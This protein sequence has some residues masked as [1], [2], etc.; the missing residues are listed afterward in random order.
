LA[1]ARASAKPT[2]DAAASA[3]LEVTTA[4][5]FRVR[6]YA[7]EANMQ[8][9]TLTLSVE[10]DFAAEAVRVTSQ[11]QFIPPTISVSRAIR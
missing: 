3:I 4:E 8:K 7:W 2:I 9:L 1:E 5:Y 6:G 11:P 10:F